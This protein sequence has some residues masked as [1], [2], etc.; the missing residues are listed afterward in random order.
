MNANFGIT[1]KGNYIIG[2]LNENQITSQ[3]ST[4]DPI[5]NLISGVI[6]LVKDGKNYVWER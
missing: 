1:K 6:M 4:E 3:N 5:V 2:Y